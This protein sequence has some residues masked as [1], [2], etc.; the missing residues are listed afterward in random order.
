MDLKQW[1]DIMNNDRIWKEMDVL[2]ADGVDFICS[3]PY[4]I[5]KVTVFRSFA[6]EEWKETKL[7]FKHFPPAYWIWEDGKKKYINNF[8][9]IS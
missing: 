6:K 9:N 5:G 7:K 8:L 2:H 1:Q 3:A 4:E